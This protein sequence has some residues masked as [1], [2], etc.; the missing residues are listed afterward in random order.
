MSSGNFST[1]KFPNRPDLNEE[2]PR[3]EENGFSKCERR[4]KKSQPQC[5]LIH[6]PQQL[7]CFCALVPSL[8]LVS[9]SHRYSYSTCIKRNLCARR[10]TVVVSPGEWMVWMRACKTN[11][12]RVS[13]RAVAHPPAATPQ[14]FQTGPE[15]RPLLFPSTSLLPGSS[16]RNS[17]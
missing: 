14:F 2:N 15:K 1:T 17:G 16:C 10:A 12:N 11:S 6:C 8:P 13:I 7:V 3:V 4:G 5:V 9:C